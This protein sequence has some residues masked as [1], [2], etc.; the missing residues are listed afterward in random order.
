MGAREGRVDAARL[1]AARQVFSR[2]YLLSFPCF[3]PPLIL[4]R[5]P[6]EDDPGMGSAS[7]GSRSNLIL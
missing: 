4:T 2:P 5:Q 1:E 3:S 7:H 6:D